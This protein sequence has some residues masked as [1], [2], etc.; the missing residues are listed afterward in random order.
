MGG[1]WEVSGVLTTVCSSL[2]LGTPDHVTLSLV[3]ILTMLIFSYVDS[4]EK[5]IIW[6]REGGLLRC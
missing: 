2:H 6:R 3:C 5:L 1:A 4:M